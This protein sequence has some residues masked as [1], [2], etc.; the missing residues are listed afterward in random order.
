[1]EV[2]D[3]SIDRAQLVPGAMLSSV[4][5]RTTPSPRARRRRQR[6]ERFRQR[7]LAGHAVVGPLLDAQARLAVDA[8]VDASS[9]APSQ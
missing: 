1:M 7:R 4:T 8:A 2:G 6:R 5:A 9:R 3:E